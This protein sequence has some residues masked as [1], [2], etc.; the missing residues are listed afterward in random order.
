MLREGSRR[1]TYKVLHDD[2][3]EMIYGRFVLQAFTWCLLLTFTGWSQSRPKQLIEDDEWT[4][5]YGLAK[6]IRSD[7]PK[8]GFV[9]SAEVAT[10]L[11]EAVAEGL[12]G[13]ERVRHEQPYRARLRGNVWTVMGTSPPLALGGVTIIQLNKDDGRILFA[14]H[15]Q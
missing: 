13:K 15:T 8:A 1:D 5:A 12:Y 10:R 14:H 9:P 11:A 7:R 6:R 4:E 3:D 2:G